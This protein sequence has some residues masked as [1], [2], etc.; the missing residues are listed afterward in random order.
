MGVEL[1]ISIQTLR[2]GDAV[3]PGQRPATEDGRS[4]FSTLFPGSINGE[5]KKRAENCQ[6]WR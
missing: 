5:R 3:L 1:R 2:A 4:R 6:I